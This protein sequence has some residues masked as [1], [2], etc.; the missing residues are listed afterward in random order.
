M[1]PEQARGSDVDERT[2]IWAFGCVLYELLTGRRAF[3]GDVTPETLGAVGRAHPTGRRCRRQRRCAS[4]RA[5][6][7]AWKG[8]PLVEFSR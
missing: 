2:D 6:G 8:T 5:C 3:S 1:S 4:E 7:A